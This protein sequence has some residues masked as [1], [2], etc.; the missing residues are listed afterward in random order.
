MHWT[1]YSPSS[2]ELLE[3]PKRPRTAYNYFFQDERQRLLDTLPVSATHRGR[4]GTHGKIGF[5][6][7]A[8]TISAKWRAISADQM[9]FY[10]NLANHDKIRYRSE[11]EVYKAQ[12]RAMQQ[13][14]TFAVQDSDKKK[15]TKKSK[16]TNNQTISND[17]PTT[18]TTAVGHPNSIM[19]TIVEPDIMESL[20]FTYE[21]A[22]SD[23]PSIADLARKLDKQSID[24]LVNAFK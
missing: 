6:D 5:A 12:E 14:A 20:P 19:M 9:F 10:A 24:F 1:P 2:T 22:A 7:L 15:K 17:T 11:V 8:K 4:P 21:S 23:F 18:T 16:R 13:Q 3:R